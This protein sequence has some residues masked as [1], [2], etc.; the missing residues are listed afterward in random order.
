MV[1]IY[2]TLGPACASE[3]VLAEMFSLG[4]TGMRLN[5]SHVTLAESG[6][7]IGKMKRAAE[8]CG[9]KPQL[10][11]DLQ[12]PELRTGTIS[13]PV[14]LKNGDIVEICGIPEKVKDSSV[15]GADRKEIAQKS[16][17]KDIEK[18]PAEKNTF[19][20]GS[21]NADRSQNKHDHVKAPGEYAK[22][23]LPGLT[24][25]YLIPGQEVLLD[26]GKIHL[27]IVEKAENVTE[28]GGENTQEKRYFAKVLWGGLLK[29]RKS[30]ALPGAKIYPPTLT[31]S[32]LANIKIAKEMGVTGVMQPFVRDHSDL[33]CVK[34]M[35]V[36]GVMQPFVRDH[37]DLECVKEALREA[38][39]ED[40]RLFAK[41]ENMDG[42]RKLEKLLPAAD[43]IV[44]ARGDLGN[45]VHLWDLPGVQRQISEK[46]RAAGKPFMVVT[47]MLASMERSPVPTR[48]EVNDIFH[49]V[50]DG[51]ASI[52]V[53]GETA[54][55]DYP[56]EVIRY[57]VNTVRSAEKEENR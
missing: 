15:S 8:K 38:G 50:M 14:S 29:S 40:I 24:F 28:N 22:I 25:P 41:I 9:V 49:A 37:S 43:E 56:V 55:G 13:E 3:K 2:G 30:A 19:G 26:D 5:L 17:N 20:K 31:N 53:T 32:D 11:V 34:E 39:A 23:M 4:M 45:A 42:V 10:L 48:A 33:E 18:I 16:E 12:G 44:I 47:Q 21:G 6:D 46:C 57:M 52:M 54:V 7:L 36:T 1:N 35:G 51:A 27:K